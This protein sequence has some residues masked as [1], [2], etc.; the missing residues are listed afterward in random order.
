M[1]VLSWW[2]KVVTAFYGLEDSYAFRIWWA[3]SLILLLFNE[4]RKI[5]KAPRDQK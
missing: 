4:V 5:G 1:I 2:A 3:K